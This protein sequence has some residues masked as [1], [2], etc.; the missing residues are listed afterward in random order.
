MIADVILSSE[1]CYN[2]MGK[3][4]HFSDDIS[5]DIG[6]DIEGNG[7]CNDWM[8]TFVEY[9]VDDQLD[10]SDSHLSEID[11]KCLSIFSVSIFDY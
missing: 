11:E 8:E 10:G 5:L 7:R 1:P 3:R 6:N 2:S 9:N 4:G